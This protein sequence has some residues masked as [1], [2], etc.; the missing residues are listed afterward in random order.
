MTPLNC[1]QVLLTPKILAACLP[2][3]KRTVFSQVAPRA[4]QQQAARQPKK[5]H[6][7][8]ASNGL[9][10][11]FRQS[12]SIVEHLTGDEQDRIQDWLVSMEMALLPYCFGVQSRKVIMSLGNGD[13]QVLLLVSGR[14]LQTYYGGETFCVELPPPIFGKIM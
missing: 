1:Q 5:S 6:R 7:K 11:Q 10:S 13:F 12:N 4:T 2:H 14:V 9:V 8:T 3:L